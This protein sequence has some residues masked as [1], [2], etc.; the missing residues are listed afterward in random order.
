MV[1]CGLVI[2]PMQLNA[3]SVSPPPPPP[4][5]PNLPSSQPNEP[6][7]IEPSFKDAITPGTGNL[8]GKVI[9]MDTGKPITNASVRIDDLGKK[10]KVDNAGEFSV[11]GID[12]TSAE[13]G[14]RDF[15]VVVQAPGYGKHTMTTVGIFNRDIT[16]ITLVM[17]KGNKPTKHIGFLPKEDRK[18][19][20]KKRNHEI[21][22]PPPPEEVVA[23]EGFSTMEFTSET[24]QPPYIWLAI[25]ELDD[26]D[27]SPVYPDDPIRRESVD[28]DF[29]LKH[30]LP[31]EWWNGWEDEAY[32]AGA[33]A[34]KTYAWYH[35]L[36]P[37]YLVPPAGNGTECDNSTYCQYYNPYISRA[38][39]DAAVDYMSSTVFKMNGS[40]FKSSHCAGTIGA[41]ET[42]CPSSPSMSQHGSHYLASLGSTT[43]EI[44]SYYYSAS[45]TL[46]YIL[47]SPQPPKVTA[48]TTASSITLE[49][50]SPTTTQY[51]IW[52]Y[53]GGWGSIATTSSTS[54]VD[55]SVSSGNTYYYIVSA[56]N[57]G[58]WSPWSYISAYAQTGLAAPQPPETRSIWIAT[59]TIG[60]KV[61][62]LAGVNTYQ[63]ERSTNASS[64]TNVYDSFPTETATSGIIAWT[65]L[66][67]AYIDETQGGNSDFMFFDTGLAS[68][69]FY[70]YRV[71]QLHDLWPTTWSMYTNNGTTTSGGWIQV[72]T[73]ASNQDY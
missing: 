37:K 43:E 60:I 33:L 68:S 39:T 42:N 50:W 35:V 8:Q 73:A 47:T 17:Q 31:Q 67:T 3:T 58:G 56:N 69:T 48:E 41:P 61:R 34:V 9:D 64:W 52:K 22:P 12:V 15:D 7:L 57:G 27:Q 55:N 25:F 6:R 18:N 29:Y 70:Y 4:Q 26:D 44:L 36:N 38:N 49:Y 66:P 1:V 5:L 46:S 13:D 54:Y 10:I 62:G 51:A 28:F 23:P 71:R 63:V 53:N 11:E 21:I 32:R 59:S 14:E 40:I 20:N 16:T 24:N 72:K 2:G 65:A 45:G 30:V 19:G